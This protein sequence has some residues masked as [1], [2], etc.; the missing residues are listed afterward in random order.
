MRCFW[1]VFWWLVHLVVLV[2]WVCVCG[3]YCCTCFTLIFTCLGWVTFELLLLNCVL[4]V[5]VWLLVCVVALSL[6]FRWLFVL[7]SLCS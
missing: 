1:F 4:H 7:V 3:V 5:L 6:R 2:V